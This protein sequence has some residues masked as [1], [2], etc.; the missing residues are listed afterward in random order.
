MLVAQD[1]QADL[2]K[3][4]SHQSSPTMEAKATHDPIVLSSP[5]IRLRS[6]RPDQLAMPNTESA[7][8]GST[9]IFYAGGIGSRREICKIDGE[10]STLWKVAGRRFNKKTGRQPGSSMWRHGHIYLPEEGE[11]EEI[12]Q[13]QTTRKL[14]RI[15]RDV[16][17]EKISLPTLKAVHSALQSEVSP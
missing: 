6:R 14:L 16:N 9:V 13:E 17:W 11:L 5:A 8:V 10:T 3:G 2:P 15:I 1:C 7:Q 12:Y 4:S